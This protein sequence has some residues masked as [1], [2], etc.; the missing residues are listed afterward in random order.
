MGFGRAAGEPANRGPPPLR[1]DITFP[2][3]LRGV[4]VSDL[5]RVVN[6]PRLPRR[7]Q[8]PLAILRQ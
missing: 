2:H 7:R 6:V 8:Q 1:A 5:E 3:R 4:P